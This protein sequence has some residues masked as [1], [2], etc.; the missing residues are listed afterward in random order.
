MA[1]HI[2][3]SIAVTR[4]RTRWG[5]DAASF[6]VGAAAARSSGGSDGAD[7]KEGGGRDG[8]GGDAD[9]GDDEDENEGAEIGG[10][11]VGKGGCG[12]CG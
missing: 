12:G 5:R 1:S 11:A 8:G 6:E 9:G 4:M 3:E 7:D 2:T 10:E